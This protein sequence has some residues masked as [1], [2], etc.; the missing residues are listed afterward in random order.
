MFVQIYLNLKDNFSKKET[1]LPKNKAEMSAFKNFWPI[2]GF[3]SQLK[4]RFAW[5][6]RIEK[7][8][9]NRLFNLRGKCTEIGDE[10]LTDEGKHPQSQTTKAETSK[11]TN[12]RL[13]YDMSM[14]V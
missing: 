10:I 12:G 7:L 5:R 11:R 14:W 6:K 2:F 8:D 9:L 3:D 4:G 1:A 13:K